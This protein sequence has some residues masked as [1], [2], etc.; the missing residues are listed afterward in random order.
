MIKRKGE[1]KNTNIVIKCAEIKLKIII[2]M[3]REIDSTTSILYQY[4]ICKKFVEREGNQ[5]KQDT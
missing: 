2:Y 3:L 1:Q 4:C 5:R